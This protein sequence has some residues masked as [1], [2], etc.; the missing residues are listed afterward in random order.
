MNN[1][2]KQ[3]NVVYKMPEGLSYDLEPNRMYRL[4]RVRAGFDWVIKLVADGF[5]KEPKK[6][7]A[8]ESEKKFSEK[9]SNYFNKHDDNTIGV[10]L[11][12][13]QGCG[14]TF[15]AREIARQSN[16]PVIIVDPSFPS[17][18]LTKY[19]S[20]FRSDVCIIFDEFDKYSDENWSTTPML[21]FLD[22]IQKTCR[23]LV[24]YTCNDDSVVNDFMVDR[25]SRIRYYRKFDAMNKEMVKEIVTDSIDD[26]SRIDEVVN[27]ITSSVKLLSYDVVTAL[28]TEINDNPTYS[29]YELAKDMNMA[30]E[31]DAPREKHEEKKDSCDL[32]NMLAKEVSKK[33]DKWD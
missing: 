12:G 31:G 19:F 24:I 2:I 27:F 25:P 21:E 16:L 7:Y 14:K 28:I 22:G 29:L 10:L 20:D 17:N 5:L 1:F 30:L 11:H 26:K 4:S 13:K 8:S 9:I 33:I 18:L 15:T 32:M 6:I 23:K 3:D